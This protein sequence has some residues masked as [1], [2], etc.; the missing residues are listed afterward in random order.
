MSDGLADHNRL[1]LRTLAMASCVPV[2]IMLI[3][4][5]FKPLW[6]DEIFTLYHGDSGKPLNYLADRR[7]GHAVHPPAYHYLLW[8]WDHIAAHPFIHKCLSLIFLALAGLTLYKI[9]EPDDRRSLFVFMLICLGS[10]WVIYFA[11]EIRPYILNFSLASV[12]TLLAPRL[13]DDRPEKR[14]SIKIWALWIGA[15]TLLSLTHYF[16]GLWFAALGL[17]IGL[18]WLGRQNYGRFVLMGIISVLC[19]AP[20]LAW[21][22]YS[23]PRMDPAAFGSTMTGGEKFFMA[24]NQFLRGLIVKTFGSNPLFTFLG[25][26]G[27]ILALRG[28]NKAHRVLLMAAALTV[29]LGFTIHMVWVDMIKER[30]FIV[31]MPGILYIMADYTARREHRFMRYLPWAAALMPLLFLGEY[32][33]NKE[34]LGALHAKIA[35]YGNACDDAPILIYYRPSKPAEF[36]DY[37]TDFILDAKMKPVDLRNAEK[38]PV[39]SC[40][41]KAAGFL[42]PKMD[43]P[44]LSEANGFLTGLGLGPDK[45]V[46][47]YF[48]KG[49]NVLWV[50]NGS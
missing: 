22:N 49:R 29:I 17:V 16:A 7:W 5:Y 3:A 24:A 1:N 18:T 20:L 19:I 46:P 48:G 30:A 34:Q 36:Y 2:L 32:F 33:K 28:Q 43:Q 10:W 6:R 11:T 38:A 37:A 15:G 41:V 4:M 40:P 12:L 9:T 39:T 13:L 50:E 42:L 23:V 47:I 31:I 25:F 27:L 45:V 44:M 26:G 8:L 14:P 35:S 21:Q